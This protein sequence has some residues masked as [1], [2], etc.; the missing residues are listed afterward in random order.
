VRSFLHPGVEATVA[1]QPLV[2][3]TLAVVFAV[4]AVV[5]CGCA[6]PGAALIPA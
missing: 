2:A 4:L 5:A 6:G 1:N 3:M